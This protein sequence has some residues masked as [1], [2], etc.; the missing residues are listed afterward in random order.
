V[1]MVLMLA[2]VAAGFHLQAEGG[3]C[4]R[5]LS[6]R[7]SCSAHKP[8]GSNFWRV[9]FIRSFPK[10]TKSLNLYADIWTNRNKFG[11]SQGTDKL[12]LFSFKS[13]EGRLK[14]TGLHWKTGS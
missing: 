14:R 4:R 9:D 10:A 5:E 7:I 12:F 2:G 6:K 11:N 1:L 3:Q 8:W 13:S